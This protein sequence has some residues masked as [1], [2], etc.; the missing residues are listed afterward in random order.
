M[1]AH[2]RKRMPD[3]TIVVGVSGGVDSAVSAA[4]LSREGFRV[5]GLFMKNWDEDD[6][7][8]CAAHEDLESA[9]QVCARLGVELHTVNFAHEYW[10]HVFR[11]FIKEYKAGRTPNP[12][13]LCNREIKFKTFLEHARGLGADKIAT[14]HYAA[15]AP[16]DAGD[17]LH[18]LRGADAGKDQSYFLYLLNQHA[19]RHTLFP[20]GGLHKTRVRKIAEELQLPCHNREDSAGICFIGEKKMHE[21]LSRYIRLEPGD[22]VD[23]DGRVVG[24]HR[25]AALYTIGQRAGLGVGGQRDAGGEP[26]YVAGKDMAANRVRIVQGRDHPALL[27]REVRVKE[28]H[29]VGRAP[30]DGNLSAQCRH[31]QTAVA[32]ELD[33]TDDGATVRFSQTVRAVAP[34]QAVVFYDGRRC[35][36]GGVADAVV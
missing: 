22:I 11:H 12:D 2:S 30:T 15:V 16:D 26:W 35:L 20:L 29:W 14:G 25:G 36:G 6:D 17:G 5:V 31:R 1:R 3:Q 9:R 24:R 34:G 7:G 23:A 10:E 32:C 4:L 28:L 18:L 8:E 19:L 33:L 13:T 27:A 21:F